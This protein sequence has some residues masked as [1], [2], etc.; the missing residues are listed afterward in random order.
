MNSEYDDVSQIGNK[1]LDNKKSDS[2]KKKK[3]GC[4]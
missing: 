2:G 3:E 1:K 4:C